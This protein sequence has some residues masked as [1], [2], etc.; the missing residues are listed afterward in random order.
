MVLGDGKVQSMIMETGGWWRIEKKVTEYV[1]TKQLTGQGGSWMIHT[2][3][4]TIQDDDKSWDRVEAW[5]PRAKTL[6]N[7][8]EYPVSQQDDRKEEGKRWY[9]L[10]YSVSYHKKVET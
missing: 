8:G 9:G 1:A 2:D 6:K 4:D 10:E 7:K 3:N 5:Q